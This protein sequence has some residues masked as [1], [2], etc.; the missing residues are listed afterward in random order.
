MSQVVEIYN[1]RIE[2]EIQNLPIT[3]SSAKDRVLSDI[4]FYIHELGT[5]N[6]TD[7]SNRLMVAVNNLKVQAPGASRSA[8]PMNVNRSASPQVAAPAPPPNQG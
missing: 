2:E 8:S 3:S 7:A 1:S 6:D 5:I 4:Q